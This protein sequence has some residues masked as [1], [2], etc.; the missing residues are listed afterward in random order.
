MDAGHVGQNMYVAATAL[1]YGCCTVG[2]FDDDAMNR[3]LG[4]DGKVEMVVYGASV[5]PME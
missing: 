5:G 3:V 2:A 4:L 1:G